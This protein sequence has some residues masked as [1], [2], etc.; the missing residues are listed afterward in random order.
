M[1]AENFKKIFA[2]KSLENGKESDADEI[3][4]IE[5]EEISMNDLVRFI[6]NWKQVPSY[7]IMK[8]N[9]SMKA[10]SISEESLQFDSQNNKLTLIINEYT[11]IV[12]YEGH[13]FANPITNYISKISFENQTGSMDFTNQYIK[14]PFA[15]ESECKCT[16]WAIK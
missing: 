16:I 5:S 13:N 3:S 10:E 1:K 2:E 4:G 8:Y 9:H 6:K 7:K 14:F 11:A 12:L 15:F